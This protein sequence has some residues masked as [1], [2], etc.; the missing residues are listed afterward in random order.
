MLRAEVGE[1][2]RNMAKRRAPCIDF[3]FMGGFPFRARV[4]RSAICGAKEN[5]VSFSARLEALLLACLLGFEWDR[6]F[7][8]A[9]N[10]FVAGPAVGV[11]IIHPENSFAGAA[12]RY[13]SAFGREGLLGFNCL[14]RSH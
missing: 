11:E 9:V 3:L 10:E 8:A 5:L 1:E 12:L 13:L 7:T 4:C 2:A 6:P 14:C